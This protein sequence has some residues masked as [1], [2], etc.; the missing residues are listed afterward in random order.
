M[1]FLTCR[2]KRDC[3]AFALIVSAII[4]VVA[5]FLLITGTIT[6]TP[7]VLYVALGVAGAGLIALALRAYGHRCSDAGRACC[8]AITAVLAGIV[9]T[10]VL[11]TVLLIVGITATSV[12]SAI[13]VGLLLFFLSLIITAAICLI[14]C[15]SGCEN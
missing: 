10:I 2:C 4:G 9:G 5:A 12:V 3:T 8:R 11:A 7:I 6:I 14:R 13:L 1:D 15:L